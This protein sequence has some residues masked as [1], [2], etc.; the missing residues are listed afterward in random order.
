MLIRTSAA[1]R[2][3]EWHF[4]TPFRR[5]R[6]GVA[7]AVSDLVVLLVAGRVVLA[8]GAVPGQ[9]VDERRLSRGSAEKRHGGKDGEGELHFDDC[10]VGGGL[11][12]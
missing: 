4:D 7:R 2:R 3:L 6:Q 9:Q 10:G 12:K 1:R 5:C 8:I 11:L